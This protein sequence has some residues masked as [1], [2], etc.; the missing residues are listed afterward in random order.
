MHSRHMR[1]LEVDT[2]GQIDGW[3]SRL[4]VNRRMYRRGWM[5]G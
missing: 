1:G 3:K 5:D 2:E 4:Q